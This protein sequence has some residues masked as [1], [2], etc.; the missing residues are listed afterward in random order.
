M[1]VLKTG[2]LV[3][4]VLVA[5]LVTGAGV[6]LASF[7]INA[8]KDKIIARIKA[9]T[10]RDLVLDGPLELALWPQIR[11]TAGPLTLS[12]VS[13]ADPTPLLRAERIQIA[14][15]TWP[16]LRKRAEM[17]TVVLHGVDLNLAR[18]AT[19]VGNWAD[20]LGANAKRQDAQT[21]RGASSQLAVLILGGVDIKD[22]R[23]TWHDAMT[24][25]QLRLTAVTATT[26]AL[27][28]GQ[29]IDLK[30]S[31]SARANQPALDAD[32]K[33]TGTLNYNVDDKHYRLAP[34]VVVSDLRG[35]QL[36]G[37]T[38]R[39]RLD[40]GLE[41]DL[42]AKT[43]KLSGL[44]FDGLG[45]RVSGEFSAH[46]IEDDRPSA[47]GQ[48]QITGVDIAALFNA[49]ALPAGKQLARVAE[50]RFNFTSAFDANMKSGELQVT[51][52][53]GQLL[54]AQMNGAFTASKAN[55][56]MPLATGNLH[57]HGPDLPSLL[58]VLAQLQG[59]D[60]KT[61]KQLSQALAGS[62]DKSF[63][64]N[65]ELDIDLG[66]GRAA[67][68][69]LDAKLLGNTF[70]G[71]VVASK[72]ASKQA[73]FKGEFKASGAD[74]PALLAVAATLQGQASSLAAM[75]QSLARESNQQFSF[76]SGFEADLA[77]GKMA[78]T[79]LAADVAGLTL[80]GALHGEDVD[81]GKRQG[82]VD[83]RLTLESADTG[84][85]LRA[86]GQ[87]DMARAVQ[88]IKLDAGV[89]GGLQD[90]RVSPLAVFAR[91]VS[92]ELPQAMEVNITAQSA[93]ANLKA[94][95][96][97][98]QRLAVTGLGLNAHVDIEAEK[99][100]ST[101]RY[102]GTVT[103]PSFN[104]RSLL[105]TLHKPIPKTADAQVLGAVAL[106]TRFAGSLSGLRVDALQ[107][108]LDDTHVQ[109]DIDV[110]AFTGPQLNFTLAVDG[111][112]ADRYLEA[113]A[114]NHSGTT[115]TPDAA[116]AGA[117]NALPV[118]VLRTLKVKGALSVS[119]LKMSGAQLKNVKVDI[120]AA[121]GVVK[122]EPLAAQLYDGRYG[123][124]VVLDARGKQTNI[125]LNTRLDKVQIAPLLHDLKDNDSLAGAVSF[126]AALQAVG[127]RAAQVKQTLTGTGRFGITDGVFRG[128]DAVA[129][130]RAVEQIIECR[131]V[132]AVPQGGQTQFK[133]LAGTLDI[134]HGMVRNNNLVMNGAGFT[135]SGAGL[136]ANLHDNS[137]KYD[138]RL[139]VA[140]HRTA[141]AK[142]TA[143]LGGY[144]VPI[145]CHGQLDNPICLPDFGHILGAVAK[146]AAKKKIEKAVGKK[147][148]G[149]IDGKPGDALKNLLK[150]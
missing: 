145:A 46:D 122:L 63:D 143:K 58:A 59:A 19:G 11:L 54:G 52:L 33:I 89:Q 106:S 41:V 15:A 61:Q 86:V 116:I 102:H 121:Q 137:L 42:N 84:P 30:I 31:A 76:E 144:E 44:K 118:A 114:K 1:K 136:I 126:D 120:D 28:F 91:V 12:N 64:V 148:K 65:V 5:L 55:T 87:G 25:Q 34:L 81:I 138:M 7:D 123:G 45:T 40:A 85:L 100:V 95:T 130:L 62:R 26:G 110:I 108:T 82:K 18:D 16:L 99:I 20:L 9:D 117:A 6:F 135:I 74:F 93:H 129:I 73:A 24:G 83:G 36:P 71:N 141:S 53:E 68:P 105:K 150:F 88:S 78:L 77:S 109:G 3:T 60:T 140:A 51:Q 10:G 43:A 17:D 98:L 72:A 112:D 29:P 48:L 97:S 124:G 92:P 103:I 4:L 94:E 50:R 39:L 115:V 104:L 90:L 80:N 139:A 32:I 22:G 113:P 96:A 21:K 69:R 66:A 125:T 75:A 134:Q 149:V 119:A 107:L 2:L 23:L 142:S 35:A 101:P 131:C 79:K 127:G 70:S 133:S 49:F 27:T 128:V 14:V 147:L 13:G 38:A 67:L 146:D 8:Y 57:A 56:A 37:G 111:I 47:T 132:V